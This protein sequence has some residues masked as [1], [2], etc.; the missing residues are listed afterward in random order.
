MSEGNRSDVKL[1]PLE[2]AIEASSQRVRQRCLAD[3]GHVLDEEVPAGQESDQGK[4]YYVRLASDDSLDR[5]LK[6]LDLAGSGD[7]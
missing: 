5:R 1:N 2:S 3:A 4:L 7:H 6:L